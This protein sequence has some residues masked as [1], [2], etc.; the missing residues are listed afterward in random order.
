MVGQASKARSSSRRK[1]RS[2][3][4]PANALRQAARTS[5]ARCASSSMNRRCRQQE[6]AAV[7]DV[8]VAGQQALDRH[9]IRL[10]DEAGNV[11]NGRSR[12]QFVAHPDIAEPGRRRRRPNA[13][14]DESAVPRRRD[15]RR[16]RGAERGV[17]AHPVIDRHRQDH[18]VGVGFA[19]EQRRNRDRRS[20]IS[21]ERLE[22]DGWTVDA[23]RAQL[24]ADREA[25]LGVCDHHRLGKQRAIVD[26][27][28]RLLQQGVFAEQREQLLGVGLARQRPQPRAGAA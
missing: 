9:E 13:E 4:A 17:I 18:G 20:G 12:I 6:Y 22:H 1:S 16:Y 14:Q 27:Q 2:R 19:G 25:V 21:S 5:G 23:D 10:L 8:L 26:A 15:A 3:L 28:R 24:F 7:P 11:A